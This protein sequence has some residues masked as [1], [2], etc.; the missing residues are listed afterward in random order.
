MFEAIK[1]AIASINRLIVKSVS[2]DE[3]SSARLSSF[4][5][6]APIQMMILVVILI[7]LVA[8]GTSIYHGKDYVLS[9]EFIITFGM[10]LSHH[11]AILFSRTKSQ[12]RK[13]LAEGDSKEEEPK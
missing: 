7:E 10:I 2:T 6:L 11:L 1:S 3:V 4:M 13:E 5:I 12:S 9:N 8:F